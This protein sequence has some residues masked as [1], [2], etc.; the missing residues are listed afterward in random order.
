MQHSW[1]YDYTVSACKNGNEVYLYTTYYNSFKPFVS[2]PQYSSAKHVIGLGITQDLLMLVD[3]DEK[4][5]QR[6]R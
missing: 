1:I 3:V 5:W 2:G 4:P 6:D